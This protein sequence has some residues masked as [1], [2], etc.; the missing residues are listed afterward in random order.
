[1]SDETNLLDE[2]LLLF[3]FANEKEGAT[4]GALRKELKTV[5]DS[6]AVDLAP[7]IAHL[8]QQRLVIE[9]PRKKGSTS[10]R[11]QLERQGS[12]LLVKHLGGKS[13]QGRG[14]KQKAARALAAARVLKVD[15]R[16]ASAIVVDDLLPEYFLA[17]RLGL[18]F[19]TSLTADGIGGHVAAAALQT[20]N[21]KSPTLW[22]GLFR[23]AVELQPS[24]PEPSEQLRFVEQVNHTLGTAKEG[25]FGEHKFFIH[26]AWETWRR[27]T[28]EDLDLSA[29]KDRLLVA[30]RGG[31]LGLARADFTETLD[32]VDV[33]QAEIRDGEETFHFITR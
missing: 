25:W 15:P 21:G 13:F 2:L 1:M 19:H 26:R 6:P 33:E 17:Q 28:G 10:V 23:R 7:K 18:E 14:W 8:V 9:L 27:Q 16:T 20:V 3:I 31:H 24:G 5:L 4:L 12:D 11:W 30:L 22:K 29:F 32:P